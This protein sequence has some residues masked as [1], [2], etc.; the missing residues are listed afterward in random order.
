MVHYTQCMPRPRKA[1]TDEEVVSAP[2]KRVSR[3]R[4]VSGSE[5]TT[6]PRR[7]STR[8]TAPVVESVDRPVRKAPTPVAAV[9]S[10]RSKRRTQFVIV[11]G[12]ALVL[13]GGGVAVGMSDT[14]TI[15]V[16]ASISDRNERINR[17]E[18][19]D[20]SGSAVTETVPVQ[21]TGNVANGG[22]KTADE[23]AAPPP[24]PE[25]TPATTTES[26]ADTATSSTN[27]LEEGST[28]ATDETAS[29]SETA[30]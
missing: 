21:N 30:A 12:I 8:V 3:T 17:G 9:L 6:T 28:D 10:S 13:A 20:A 7:R 2:R 25:P 19:L 24:P 11:A 1:I 15:D 5:E 14:G 22:F 29:T 4:T 23:G 16:V 18:V 26:V 27:I